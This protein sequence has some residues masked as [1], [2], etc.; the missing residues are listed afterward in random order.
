MSTTPLIGII[1]PAYNASKLIE[2]TIASVQSQTFTDWEM[3]IVDDGSKDNTLE[4]ITKISELD[5]RIK[6]FSQANQGPAPAR[7]LALTKTKARYICFLDSDDL[8]LPT[9]LQDQLSFMHQEDCALSFTQFR[10]INFYGTET[11]RLIPVP[12]KV[13]YKELLTHNVIACLT[14]MIDTTK[15][16]P[17]E[18][19][20]EGYDDFIL[21]LSV[22]KKG[23]LGKGLQKDLARYRIVSGS[24]SSK[25]TRAIKWVWNIYRKVER[26]SLLRSSIYMAQYLVKVSLKHSSF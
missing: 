18:I 23:Y 24:V 19:S 26:L 3:I 15:T 12:K 20:D 21:W 13:S 25:R 11:G 17:L 8:W 14:V 22:L 9:K 2:Q 5:P 16:G 7:R 6:V 10:R 4:I 1:T